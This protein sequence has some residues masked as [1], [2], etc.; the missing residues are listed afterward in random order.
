MK[1]GVKEMKNEY[2]K[3]NL[4]EIE[5]LQDDLEDMLE[6][7]NEVQVRITRISNDFESVALRGAVVVSSGMCN[8]PHSHVFSPSGDPRSVL[9]YAG[10]D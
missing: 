10:H 8:K 9:Q 1:L 2:K 5:D 4:N 7:A 3:V 6:Q